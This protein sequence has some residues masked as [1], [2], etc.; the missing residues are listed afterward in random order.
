MDR[1]ASVLVAICGSRHDGAPVIDPERILDRLDG[2]APARI[3]E[4]LCRRPAAVRELAE[5]GTARRL[6]LAVCDGRPSTQELR[7]AGSAAGLDPFGVEV[8]RLD[9]VGALGPPEAAADRAAAAIAGAVESARR[10]PPTSGARL[11]PTLEGP[12]ISRRA[13][14]TLG[15]R[16]SR[17][18]ASVDQG[19]CLGSS[20]CGLCIF[21]CPV[22][23]ILP[24][25]PT[26]TVAAES[27]IACGACLAWCPTGAVGLPAA[28]LEAFAARIGTIASWPW[29]GRPPGILLGCGGALVRCT[30]QGP[31]AAPGWLPVPLPC[32]SIVTAAWILGAL[33]AGAPAVGL[34]GCGSGCDAG[35]DGPARARAA[36]CRELLTS[37]GIEPERV[38]V[39][40]PWPIPPPPTDRPLGASIERLTLRE[41]DGTAAAVL[42]LAPVGSSSNGAAG[43]THP[44][45]PL[46]AVVVDEDGCT[47][48]GVCAEA[49]PT[50]ALAFEQ[51]GDEAV[52][53]LDAARCLA[54]DRCA[55]ACPEHVLTIERRTDPDRIRQGRRRLTFGRLVRCTRCGGPVAPERM[56][57]RVA[58]M[59]PD[60]PPWL[61]GPLGRR[62]SACRGL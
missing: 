59:L 56:L 9:V 36:Y 25:T 49:C 12:A 51:G 17:P 31:T 24:S 10:E 28:S 55:A 33:A 48:C 62:C 47:L 19:A 30:E 22:G 15:R 27:C 13:L 35:S 4:R 32:L 41:P 58:E 16:G 14:I 37:V 45:S 1:D 39:L 29:E 44:A 40:E 50:G 53:T 61:L 8:L 18:V 5:E 3:V 42:A 20:Q 46:G 11:A 54:C 7:E 26:P 38:L 60:D 2:S 21:A 6:A 52:L 43:L 23:A 34:L 57:A